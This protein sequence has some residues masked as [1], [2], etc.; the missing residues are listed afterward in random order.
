MGALDAVELGKLGQDDEAT[1]LLPA[2][3][4]LTEADAIDIWIAR[5][6]RIRPRAL[7]ERYRCDPRRLYE[8]WWGDRFPASRALAE[9]C[10]RERYPGLAERT[11]F[12]YRRIP[13]VAA[14]ADA[15]RQLTLFD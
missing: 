6:L 15:H 8:I 2:Q 10:F 14:K 11:S 7:A 5:W 9:R 12:G 4:M 1:R 3:R 13:V